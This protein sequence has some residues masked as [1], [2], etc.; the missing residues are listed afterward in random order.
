VVTGQRLHRAEPYDRRDAG[1][2]GRGW[3]GA[4]RRDAPHDRQSGRPTGGRNGRRARPTAAGLGLSPRWGMSDRWE[5]PGHHQL[6]RRGPA[7]SS[8]KDYGCC[9]FNAKHSGKHANEAARR[10]SLPTILLHWTIAAMIVN[11]V[12]KKLR[13]LTT[14]RDS[15]ERPPTGGVCSKFFTPALD[16]SRKDAHV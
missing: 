14:R 7:A 12:L 5:T 15:R 9:N 16:S 8:R 2:L 11:Q 13:T 1:R 4:R 6:R 3:F 10:Y